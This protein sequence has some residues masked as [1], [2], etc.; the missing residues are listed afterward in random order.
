MKKEKK[1]ISGG[2][3]LFLPYAV[4]LIIFA[5]GLKFAVILSLSNFL[6]ICIA[7][8]LVLLFAQVNMMT[9]QLN[10]QNVIL[11]KKGK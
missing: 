5:F 8:L 6:L 2:V 10:V 4:A 1:G 3:A 9:Y 11:T 7:A